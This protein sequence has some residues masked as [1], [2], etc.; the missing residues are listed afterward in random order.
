MTAEHHPPITPAIAAALRELQDLIAARYP[1]ATFVVEGGS[2]PPGIYLVATVDVEDTDE[3]F[4]L[5]VERL[6]EL[7]IDEGLPVYVTPV[8]PIT[9]S[10]EALQAR[11]R[12]APA[13]W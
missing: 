8:R 13:P 10:I 12:P 4:D 7:Q 2:E 9:R 1:E 11:G 6:L 5:V 3:V